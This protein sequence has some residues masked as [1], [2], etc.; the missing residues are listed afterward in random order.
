MAAY[1]AG[2]TYWAS[3]PTDDVGGELASR[4]EAYYR[5]ASTSPLIRRIILARRLIMGLESKAGA[6]SWEVRRGGVAGELA[7]M[8]SNHFGSVADQRVNLAL[9]QEPAW[10]PIATNSDYASLAQSTTVSGVLDYYYR[11]LRVER[12]IRKSADDMQWAGEGFVL[13]AWDVAKGRAVAND[14]ESG[15][16]VNEGDLTFSNPN[17]LDVVRDWQANSWD[18]LSW[19]TVRDFSNKWDIA[20]S[21]PDK[22]DEILG[23]SGDAWGQSARFGA[24]LEQAESDQIPV[25]HFFHE[26]TPALPNGR[27]VIFLSGDIVLFDGDLPYRKSPLFRAAE[28]EI[29]GTPFGWSAA[30]D[31]MG[32]QEV[33]DALTTAIVSHQSAMAIPKIVGVKG[34]GIRYKD[35]AQALGYIEVNDKNQI[36][37]VLDLSP[38]GDQVYAFRSALVQEV[39]MFQGVNDIQ[40]GVVNPAIKSGAH[41]ALYDAIAL[42]ASSRLQK[43]VYALMEDVGTFV[44][45]TLTDM[46]GDSERI[47]RIAGE[48]NRPLVIAFTP[49]EDLA[50]F[51]RVAIEAT[52]HTGK[53]AIGKQAIADALLE[54]SALGTGDAVAHRYV[55]LIKTG[56]VEQLTEGPQSN[57]LRLKRDKEL[58]AKGIGL[59]PL[60][61]VVDPISG[62]PQLDPMTGQPVTKR[63]PE[64]GK[65]YVGIHMAQPHWLDIPEYLSVLSSPEAL[66]SPEVTAAVLEVVQ[67][68]LNLWRTMDPDL[69]MLLGGSPP[70]SQ[71]MTLPPADG[72]GSTPTQP[73]GGGRQSETPNPQ[74]PSQLPGP[75]DL[76]AKP[77][78]LPRLPGGSPY[79]PDQGGQDVVQ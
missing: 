30:F 27:Y 40:R 58:M 22:R 70:P 12:K 47:A 79:Q 60:G 57:A 23:V 13:G 54:K 69:M 8:R 61:P 1:A 5:W 78:G 35:L 25:F 52:N 10:Q 29:D 37:Q 38:M 76:P 72:G 71:S 36:P 59:A 55:Q 2:G 20:C 46:A 56:E 77:A 39:Q 14:P 67:E 4:V 21:H 42:R 18:S 53:T 11:D 34:S 62:M 74:N 24:T 6:V 66:Q 17:T 16:V 28:K 7:K 73:P 43:A 41:A 65:T 63:Q 19:H 31:A 26:R 50:G 68:K 45:H 48:H 9:Q 75:S 3:C 49:A 15:E 33:V 51:D 64:Q 44:L 32:P